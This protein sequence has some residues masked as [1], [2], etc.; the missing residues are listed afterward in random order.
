VSLHAVSASMHVTGGAI[1]IAIS[2][3]SLLLP[4]APLPES[5]FGH[6]FCEAHLFLGGP[7]CTL[8]VGRHVGSIV[9]IAKFSCKSPQPRGVLCK[10]SSSG[11]DRAGKLAPGSIQR[12]VSTAAVRSS[13]ALV[14]VDLT[15]FL[16]RQDFC[17]VYRVRCK[18]N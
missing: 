17:R 3:R 6:Q 18:K 7:R 14:V 4:S 15:L 11:L 13:I 1:S 5:D 2:I 12:P 10:P 9:F 8:L 16:L